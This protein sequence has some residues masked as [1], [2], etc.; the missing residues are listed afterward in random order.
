MGECFCLE[1]EWKLLFLSSE[2]LRYWRR[3]IE[4]EKNTQILKPKIDQNARIK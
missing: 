3:L 2:K 1:G 4:A